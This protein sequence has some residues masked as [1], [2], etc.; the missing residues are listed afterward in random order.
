ML[1]PAALLQRFDRVVPGSRQSRVRDR[2]RKISRLLL[3]RDPMQVYPRL[4]S[5]VK[6]PHLLLAYESSPRCPMNDPAWCPEVGCAITRGAVRDLV[7]YMPDDILTKT[8]RVSMA[9]SLEAREPLTDHRLVE[10]ALRIPARFKFAGGRN[11]ILLRDLLDR[12]VPRALVERPKM[13]FSVPIDHWLRG[14]LR[15][16]GE[17]LLDERRLE[18]E[19]LLDA[20]A[21]RDLWNQHQSG[22]SQRQWELWNCLMLETWM[23]RW[24]PSATAS[25]E[26]RAAPAIELRAPAEPAGPASEP[27]IAAAAIAATSPVPSSAA[28]RDASQD[29]SRE[30][31]QE[32]PLDPSPEPSPDDSTRR[33]FAGGTY[34]GL[35]QALVQKGSA[36]LT[37]LVAA[38]TLQPGDV[39]SVTTAISIAT[40]LSFIFPGAAG[41]ILTHRQSTVALWQTACLWLSG[42]AGLLL[43]A[44]CLAAAPIIGWQ[45][46]DSPVAMFTALA[47]VRIAFDAASMVAV[48]KLRLRGRFRLL[49]ALDTGLAVVTLAGTTALGVLGFA[50][51]ALLLPMIIV[52]ALRFAIVV[53]AASI[54]LFRPGS[55]A[56]ARNL[57]HDFRAGGLQHYLNGVTQTV[58]YFAISLFNTEAVLGRYTIAYQLAFTLHVVIAYTVAGIAQPVFSR[59]Q[60]QPERKRETFVATQRLTMAVAAPLFIGLAIASPVLVKM[61]L[62]E[63]WELAWI[64]ISILSVAFLLMNPIQISAALM[65]ARGRFKHLL[66][67]QIAQTICLTIAVF[68]ATSFGTARHVAFAVCLVGLVFG[69]LSI[70]AALAELGGAGRAIRDIY[71]A[72]ILAAAV[73]LT[74]QFLLLRAL[75]DDN[76]T[77]LAVQFAAGL[78]GL[79]LYVLALRVV[80]P[81]LHGQVRGLLSEIRTRAARP[82]AA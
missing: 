81:S 43:V 56:R 36:F 2:L 59:L 12:H 39:G 66:R 75:G 32:P 3:E 42:A 76:W 13:G 60:G 9:V 58:D 67:F 27:V 33:Q 10:L 82:L 69:P 70:R 8:D 64:S 24:G 78:A 41:D 47:A 72:P 62:P 19:G 35:V 31:S 68:A 5:V 49:A 71:L 20:H 21:V 29:A 55:L 50:G 23:E 4:A 18:G 80:S 74:P 34:W 45:Y 48:A 28:A 52:A 17:H 26:P 25:P 73:C 1:A 46:A 16:W 40:L 57:W 15:E 38:W 65:R 63:R 30:A 77:S 54:P 79:G 14:E 11:K 44:I 37:Y 61:L 22:D 51:W 53:S 6:D 7:S